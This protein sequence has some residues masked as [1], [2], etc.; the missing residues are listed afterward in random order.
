MPFGHQVEGL[1]VCGH[2]TY[3]VETDVQ[4]QRVKDP[5][6]VHKLD[7]VQRK[8]FRNLGTVIQTGLHERR[9]GHCALDSH[10][11][12]GELPSGAGYAASRK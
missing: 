9:G 12:A 6:S 10:E 1:M 8:G 7:R 11:V 3:V 4:T 2:K 5:R